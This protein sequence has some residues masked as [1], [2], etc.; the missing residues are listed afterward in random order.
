MA[1]VYYT[2][3]LAV[4]DVN[5]SAFYAIDP[6]P[7]LDIFQ[8]GFT[9]YP[10]Q[11]G[12]TSVAIYPQVVQL[13]MPAASYIGGS[14]SIQTSAPSIDGNFTISPPINVDAKLTLY[15]AGGQ[16]LGTVI[17]AGGEPSVAFEWK[18]SPGQGMTADEAKHAVQASLEKQ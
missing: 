18:V 7:G 5:S 9:C 11:Q 15:G 6:V 10:S 4:V 16:E 13:N 3:G 1:N 14:V 2:I 17:L 8:G 12:N